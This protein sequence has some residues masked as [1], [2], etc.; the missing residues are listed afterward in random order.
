[1]FPGD[2][3]R[4][5]SAS[6]DDVEGGIGQSAHGWMAVDENN[7]T[8]ESRLAFGVSG[9]F[10]FFLLGLIA[11]TWPA[12]AI[13]HSVTFD[14]AGT[15]A[16]ANPHSLG[17]IF[18]VP[19]TSYSSSTISGSFTFEADVADSDGSGTVGQYNIGTIENLSFSVTKPITGDAYQFGLDLSGGSGRPV[20]NSIAVNAHG[21]AINQSYVLSAS[22]QNVLP[23]GPIFDGGDY[24]AREFFISLL[25]PSASVF[26]SDALPEAPPSLSPFSLYNSVNNPQGQFRLVFQSSHGDH[27]L[28]GN[29]NSLT[30]APVPLPAAV[31]FFG[32]GVIGLI[33]LARRKM[34]TAA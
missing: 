25:K 32:S 15:V 30:Q 16:A 23:A 13:A 8:M 7:R 14:F 27:T 12:T 29:L 21:T 24:F 26:T 33:G 19:I 10:G 1:V 28:F 2:F 4:R 11:L 34:N 18:T 20:Q 22:V 17:G 3:A 5:S 9:L 6:R 31:W